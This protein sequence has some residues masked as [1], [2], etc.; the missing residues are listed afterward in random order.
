MDWARELVFLNARNYFYSGD[1]SM[2][3]LEWVEFGNGPLE[4]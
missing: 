3:L 2:E 4:K 1:V